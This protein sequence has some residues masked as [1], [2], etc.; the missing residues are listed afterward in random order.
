MRN[1][2][3]NITCGAMI[4][5]MYVILTMIS[6][7]IG[8]DSGAIQLRLSEALCVMPCFTVSAV[9]GL[10]VGCMLSNIFAGATVWDI[11]FGSLA[12]LL[13]AV[14]TYKLRDRGS[15]ALLPPVAANTVILPFVLAYSY[16]AKGTVLYFMLTIGVSEVISCG[17]LG[18][19]LYSA[20]I[21]HK[22]IF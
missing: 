13:G 11:I 10:F 2:T 12:T 6:R 9:W 3:K 4:A 17:I 15:P 18:W 8:M 5:A 1:N 7:T 19:V 21:K 20:M 16:R 14:G 22:R